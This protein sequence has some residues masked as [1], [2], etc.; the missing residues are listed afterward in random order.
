MDGTKTSLWLF[1]LINQLPLS[2]ANDLPTT[3]MHNQTASLTTIANT[4]YTNHYEEETNMTRAECLMDTQLGLI[5]LGSAGG[6]IVCLLVTTVVLAC[7]ICQLQRRVYLPRSSRS[8]MDLVGTADYWGPD[9]AEAGGLVGPCDTSVMLEELGADSRIERERQDEFQ[10]L[11]EEVVAE[12][13]EEEGATAVPLLS[14]EAQ[15][16]QMLSSASRD[17]CL[18]VPRD[19]EDMPL[20]V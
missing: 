16:G 8:N 17:S 13:E 14:S 12:L 15:G 19:L 5:A 6:L 3:Q 7:Q 4:S 20:V 11:R 18:E 1:V 2:L 9:Q 10:E